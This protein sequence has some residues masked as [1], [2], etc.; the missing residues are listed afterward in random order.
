[1]F[2]L[3]LNPSFCLNGSPMNGWVKFS[4]MSPPSGLSTWISP[5]SN[6]NSIYLLLLCCLFGYVFSECIQNPMRLEAMLSISTIIKIFLSSENTSTA[7][8]SFRFLLYIINLFCHWQWF[9]FDT[10]CAWWGHSGHYPCT[11]L[12]PSI[13]FSIH[14]Q[15]RYLRPERLQIAQPGQYILSSNVSIFW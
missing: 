4:P 8:N 12:H 5:L 7:Q 11:H 2:T 9:T 15:S 1:M 10:V 13:S 14:H 3:L 6:I